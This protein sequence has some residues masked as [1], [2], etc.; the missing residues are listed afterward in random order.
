MEP[1]HGKTF[2]LLHANDGFITLE[3]VRRFCDAVG[4]QPDLVSDENLETIERSLE[5][6]AGSGAGRGAPPHDSL[7]VGE[8][9]NDYEVAEDLLSARKISLYAFIA[10]LRLF[11]LAKKSGEELFFAALRARIPQVLH[12]IKML[13]VFVGSDG[14]VKL[15][16][17]LHALKSCGLPVDDSLSVEDLAL[18]AEWVGATV[19]SKDYAWLLMECR[20][21]FEAFAAKAK[22]A[23]AL[24][25]KALFGEVED[26]NLLK[27][28]AAR[29]GAG[30]RAVCSVG[31]GE[32]EGLYIMWKK[33][34]CKRFLQ[35]SSHCS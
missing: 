5:L 34:F 11:G 24:A 26:E 23:L 8:G 22:K 17:V 30:L 35:Q 7:I 10:K 6:R 14:F 21:H 15:A 12:F 29:A 33:T 16:D 13:Q 25:E 27:S 2:T 31:D 3:D 19:L 32:T 28:A 20:V 1:P 18:I 4:L 9:E